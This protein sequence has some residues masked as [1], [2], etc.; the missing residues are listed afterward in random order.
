[1]SELVRSILV[2]MEDG[3]TI[4]GGLLLRALYEHVLKFCWIAADSETRYPVWRSDGL[5]QRRKLHD[6]A[7]PFGFT[8]LDAKQLAEAQAATDR[9]PGMPEL[10]QQVDAFW[11]G[12]ID[13][14]RSRVKGAPLRH[15]RTGGIAQDPPR[16]RDTWRVLTR[17]LPDITGPTAGLEIEPRSPTDHSPQRARDG[18]NRG[19]HRTGRTA[20]LTR[21]CKEP[22]STRYPT[23]ASL[24][25]AA[26]D[27]TELIKQRAGHKPCKQAALGRIE[28]PTNARTAC[29]LPN[30]EGQQR[31]PG[32]KNPRF[33]G[34]FDRGAEIRTRDLTDPN[35]ARYQAAP[36]PDAARSIPYERRRVSPVSTAA[37][38]RRPMP[39]PTAEILAELDALLE[40]ERF[41]DYWPERPAGPGTGRGARRSP[42]AC[43]PA[44]SCSSSPRTS[45]PIC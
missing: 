24:R 40:P 34:V 33:P 2:L 7:L 36:R 42:R 17:P 5:V 38:Y 16:S 28:T 12:R 25:P 41:E 44:R 9:L 29:P 23:P 3:R 43:R 19:P 8:I 31:A 30:R 4:D 14:F 22:G 11:G 21:S 45:R 13:A 35:G 20:P 6:D 26:T 39:T 15:P 1:M 10:A 37:G 32:T 27:Y 18:D